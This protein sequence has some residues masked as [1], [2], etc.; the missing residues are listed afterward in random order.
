MLFDV[1]NIF[2]EYSF[3]ILTFEMLFCIKLPRR[4]YFP[5]RALVLILY[6]FFMNR[7]L[8]DLVGL[9]SIKNIL[10]TINGINFSYIFVFLITLLLLWFCF[11]VNFWKILFIGTASYDIQHF[12]TFS[13]SVLGINIFKLERP[14]YILFGVCYLALL[15]LLVYF[16]PVRIYYKKFYKELSNKSTLIVTSITVL[17]ISIYSTIINAAG[18]FNLSSRIYA[19]IVSIILLYVLFALAHN[20]QTM[21]E[22]VMMEHMFK[23]QSKQKEIYDKNIEALNVKYHDLKHQLTNL[24]KQLNNSDNEEI[25]ELENVLNAFSANINTNNKLLDAIFYEKLCYGEQY[26]IKFDC[27]VDGSGIDF[28]SSA[29][30]CALFG[31]AL[32]NAIEAVL[33]CNE[34]N[35]N[36]TVRVKGE[37]SLFRILVENYY[38]KELNIS[39]SGF[40]TSKKDKEFHGYGIKSMR[41]ITKKYNGNMTIDY[42]D[43][44]FRLMFMFPID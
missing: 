3:T 23:A 31:N 15:S 4:R 6:L 26:G 38:D 19:C 40:C 44:S 11:D 42:S 18:L 16:L 1:L 17:L 34:E 41:Y 8:M 28:M 33:K 20:Q 12:Y 5:L 27:L 37:N 24:K 9:P 32:D 2:L 39:E 10:F 7:I 14:Y 25:H 30:I 35:R 29:D 36:I 21:S 13:F 43:N 22:N